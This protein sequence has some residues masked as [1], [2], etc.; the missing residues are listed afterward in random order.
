MKCVE[1]NN[2]CCH[3]YYAGDYGSVGNLAFMLDLRWVRG[4][5]HAG[6]LSL[7]IRMWGK[8][9]RGK[10]MRGTCRRGKTPAPFYSVGVFPRI[11]IPRVKLPRIEVHHIVLRIGIEKG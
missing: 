3:L 2:L 1:N 10:H 9:W 4:S 7:S 5:K 8:A 6:Y 11:D